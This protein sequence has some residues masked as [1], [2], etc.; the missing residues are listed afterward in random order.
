MTGCI[1]LIRHSTY[2]DDEH[3]DEPLECELQKED[4][5]MDESYKSLLVRGLTTSWAIT[6]HIRSGMTTLFSED[7][8]IDLESNELVLP[9]DQSWKVRRGRVTKWFC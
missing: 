5:L 9:K 7:A 4:L 6:N 1:I 8:I 3:R 2:D